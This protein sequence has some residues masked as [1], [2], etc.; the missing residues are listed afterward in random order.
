M[1][2]RHVE[3]PGYRWFVGRPRTAATPRLEAAPDLVEATPVGV[4]PDAAAAELGAGSP[5][6]RLTEPAMHAQLL[7]RPEIPA[8]VYGRLQELL[9]GAPPRRLGE[10]DRWVFEGALEADGKRRR[11]RLLVELRD[12]ALEVVSLGFESPAPRRRRGASSPTKRAKRAVRKVMRERDSAEREHRK[13]ERAWRREANKRQG[14][15]HA[16]VD[17]LYDAM[18]AARDRARAAKAQI[19]AVLEEQKAQVFTPEAVAAARPR[20]AV[21][22]RLAQED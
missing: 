22:R 16:K 1:V 8:R 7:S 13:A 3:G 6:V 19:V 15:D 11:A 10:S 4:L 5:V 17:G 20:F 2:G 14:H 9:D 12:G 18:Q 21:G